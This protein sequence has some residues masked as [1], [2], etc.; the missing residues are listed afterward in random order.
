MRR[1]IFLAAL[2]LLL[3]L[4]A[5]NSF[6]IPTV[7][8]QTPCSTSGSSSRSRAEGLVST[9]SLTGTF[10]TTGGCIVD[11]KSAFVPFKIP[12]YDELK[13]IYYDQKRS[14]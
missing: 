9:P 5:V 10:T 1:V 6:Q 4:F 7:F 2:L 13:S 3:V 14:N 12:T 11:T 8:A